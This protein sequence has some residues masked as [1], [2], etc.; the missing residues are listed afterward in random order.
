MNPIAQTFIVSEPES[1][2]DVVFVTAIDLFF[3]KK[4]TTYGIELQIRETENGIPTTRVIPYASKVLQPSQIN[5]SETAATA[6]KFTFDTPVILRTNVQYAITVSPLGGDPG[7]DI[8]IGE[9]GANDIANPTVPIFKNNQ[10]GSLFVSSNDLNFIQRPTDNLKYTLYTAEFSQTS[11]NA[12]FRNANNDFFRVRDI[13]GTFRPGEQIMVSNGWLELAALNLSGA[14]VFTIGE[15]I[16]QSSSGSS[17]NTATGKVYFANTTVVKVSNL[18]G[19]FVSTGNTTVV[20]ATSSKTSVITA[21][22]QNVVTT[23]ATNVITVPDPS[24]SEFANGNYIAVFTSSTA[25]AQILQITANSTVSRTLTLSANVNFSDSAARITAVYANASLYGFLSS[26]TRS[27]PES[28]FVVSGVNSNSSVNFANTSGKQ[29]I[30]RD[31]GASAYVISLVD[32]Y[33]DSV[34]AQF[35][36]AKPRFTGTNWGFQGISN[37]KTLDAAYNS[38]RQDV[39]YEFND[40]QRMIMSR[41]NELKA[42]LAIGGSSGVSSLKIKS[43]LTT[44]NTKSSPYID[45]IRNHAV[46]THNMI[47]P[48]SFLNGT[49]LN[50]ANLTGYFALGDTIWQANATTN[51]TATVVASDGS[52]IAVSNLVSS[53]V[54]HVPG[55]SVGINV[56]STNITSNGVA[57][58][59][60]VKV[61]NEAS[62]PVS[63]Q[64]RYISKNVVL[65]DKQDSEDLICYLTAYRPQETNILVY[66]QFSSA[67]DAEPIT[68]K[69]WSRLYENSIS[70]GL[71]SSLVNRDD[72][73]ELAYDLPVSLQLQNNNVSTNATSDI[74][75]FVGTADNSGIKPGDFVYIRDLSYG[76]AGVSIVAAGSG[77]ATGDQVRINGGVAG[78]L[79]AN[80]VLSVVANSTGNVVGLSVISKGSYSNNQALTANATA[81]VT[82]S[83][84]GLTLSVNTSQYEQS[85][86]FNVRKVIAMPN[87]SAIILNSNNSFN[88]GNS[89]I[90]AAALGIIPGLETQYGA[91]KYANNEGIIR[92]TT[93]TDQIFDSYKTFAVK[94]V[95]VSNN[96]YIVPRLNDMRAIALQV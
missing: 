63:D 70:T 20:G 30:G 71:Y 49:A 57:N 50:I 47:F 92:Y 8:W 29:L 14:N 45:T 62:F 22:Y 80:A 69:H 81:N 27:Y 89:T 58:V 21:A 77:Y 46:F 74:V 48:E 32:M 65:A 39:P 17:P 35:T 83:G 55:F 79:N 61:Y 75:N 1:G 86:K 9:L 93:A 95:F 66:G 15:T 10:L 59:T 24:Y 73:V 28:T 4:S 68:S 37:T 13:V 7:Y 44:S 56:N 96:S 25:N 11:G 85:T 12:V 94:L 18:N 3:R 43:D 40:Q 2:V 33:F 42:G 16:Y 76:V 38:V 5:I 87:T 64:S 67:D 90:G 78:I 72:Y 19:A 52:F 41:S 36:E 54:M 31:S 51:T 88:T 26:Q 6:T 53:N 23:S 34:T 84:T 91:F 82:G 60:A